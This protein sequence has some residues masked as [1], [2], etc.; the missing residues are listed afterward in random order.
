MDFEISAERAPALGDVRQLGR[1]DVLRLLDGWQSRPDWIR[2][3]A[4]AAHALGRGA[5]VVIG[6]SR[7]ESE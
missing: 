6:G 1:G 2:Y 5:R 4:A 7:G 3:L